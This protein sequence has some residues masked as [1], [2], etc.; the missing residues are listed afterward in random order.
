MIYYAHQW[1][2]EVEGRR[3]ITLGVQVPFPL[4]KGFRGEAR[5]RILHPVLFH[6]FLKKMAECRSD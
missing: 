3:A 6:R 1:E 2:G 5:Y 4:V